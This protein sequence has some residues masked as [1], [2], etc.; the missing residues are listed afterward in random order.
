MS[1]CVH[2]SLQKLTPLLRVGGRLANAPIP[3]DDRFPALI[4]KNHRFILSYIEYLHR[5]HLHAGPKVLL[6]IIRQKI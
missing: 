4:P 5:L 1:L 6:G 3:Y 2:P